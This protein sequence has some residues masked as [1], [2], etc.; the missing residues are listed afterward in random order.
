[1]QLAGRLP[2]VVTKPD[3]TPCVLALLPGKKIKELDYGKRIPLFL[4]WALL[5][6]DP[7]LADQP[8]AIAW[9]VNEPPGDDA[10]WQAWE[11]SW[12]QADT[13]NRESMHVQ[14][15]A[16]V[17]ELLAL[18]VQAQAQPSA[19]FPKTA[20][21]RDPAKAWLSGFSSM[22]ERDY[23]PGYARLLAGDATFSND[24]EQAALQTVA[25][26]IEAALALPLG[27]AA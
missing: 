10:P 11:H 25:D 1:W 19:Y 26:R 12:Q 21:A 22:G 9:L 6:L 23:A 3:G 16:S 24:A 8:V 7:A 18:F 14:L 2:D 13:P 15:T 27:D 20:A 4:Q 17:I 5:R